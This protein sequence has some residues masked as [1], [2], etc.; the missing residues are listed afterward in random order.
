MDICIT[1]SSPIDVLNFWFGCSFDDQNTLNSVDYIVAR[2]GYWFAG[3]CR[4]F[5]KVQKNNADLVS[6][7]ASEDLIDSEWFTPLGVLARII[8][9]DQFTRCIY[10]G[11][12][13]AFEHDM[14]SCRLIKGAKE[15]GW[16]LNSYV[17]I[18]RFFIGVAAQHAEDLTMQDIGVQI[19]RTVADGYNA[20]LQEYFRGIKGY[21]MEHWEVI[22]RFGRFPSRN[23]ALVSTIHT[24]LS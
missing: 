21:P 18:Q 17:P 8:L 20:D 3:K 11:T 15:A 2:M 12:P 22:H 6:K 14:L 4:D 9:L 5:D 13:R 24:K 10:R 16:L 19:A 23:A 7:V 1:I